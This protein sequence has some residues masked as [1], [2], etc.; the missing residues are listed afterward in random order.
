M[1]RR[2]THTLLQIRKAVYRLS[3]LKK[4][5]Q[6]IVRR[7]IGAERLKGKPAGERTL[8]CEVFAPARLDEDLLY[9]TKRVRSASRPTRRGLRQSRC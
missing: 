4:S 9:E 8:L 1:L 6:A 2:S 5:C 7:G 3:T